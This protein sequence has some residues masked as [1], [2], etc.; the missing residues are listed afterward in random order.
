MQ[1]ILKLELIRLKRLTNAFHDFAIEK[2]LLAELCAVVCQSI[3]QVLLRIGGGKKTVKHQSKVCLSMFQNRTS[4]SRPEKRKGNKKKNVFIDY[5]YTHKHPQSHY[6]HS[7]RGFTGGS[8]K[9]LPHQ[10]SKTWMQV[11]DSLPSAVPDY[12]HF[13][14]PIKLCTGVI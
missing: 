10:P 9:P 5:W 12:P 8:T 2:W 14:L 1:F 4:H 11:S 3:C 6:S 13:Y 7:S